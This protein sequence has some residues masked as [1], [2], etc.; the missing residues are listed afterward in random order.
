MRV[1]L[2]GG[3]YQSRSIIA[4]AQRC[5]NLYPEVNQDSPPVKITH[6]LTPGLVKRGECPTGRC[7]MLYTASN[8]NVYALYGNKLYAVDSSYNFTELY[9]IAFNV[10]PAYMADNGTIA[11]LVDGT[12]NGYV[13]NLS[14]NV[15]TPI[16]D[17]AFYGATRVCY[18]D[19]YFVFNKPNTPIFYISPINWNGV[20]AFDPLDFGSK[21]GAADNIS[22][23]IVMHAEIW[24][25]GNQQ[26]TEIYYNS[27]AADFTFEQQPGTFIEHGTISPYS[28][29]KQDLV[30]Y[31]LSFDPQGK[32]MV[33]RGANLQV[34]RISTHAIENEIGRYEVI[35]DAIGWTYQQ[36]GHVFY[37][38][39]FPTANKTWVY[40]EASKLWHERVWTDSDGGENRIRAAACTFG[41][42]KNLVGDW[43]N[44]NLY[45][46]ELDA[47]SDNGD[48]IVRRRGFPHS[49]DEYDRVFYWSFSADMEVGTSLGTTPETAPLVSLRWSD[50]RGASWNSPITQSMGATGQYKTDIQWN[51]LG[52]ARDRVFELFWSTTNKT[53]LNG[54]FI[55]VSKSRS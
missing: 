17:P 15:V 27:G 4:N 18:I 43:Q 34:Q 14:T 21:S 7:R 8:G 36:D 6:M 26:S 16:S 48:P 28:L 31:W 47:Y 5:V 40:D 39:T 32:A 13:V 51:R 9:T 2:T 20:D 3:F 54:A 37:V 22:T 45:S 29:A 44:G 23:L 30:V 50:S 24:L 52:M 33:L 11:V 38:L 55:T 12:A 42:N 53:A 49:I 41:Y 25:V 10:T 35:S 19:G 1:E 46:W